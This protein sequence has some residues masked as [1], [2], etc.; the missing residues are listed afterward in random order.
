MD[1]SDPAAVSAYL[2]SDEV[3]V[4]AMPGGVSS[5]VVR[6]QTPEQSFVLKRALPKL[7]VKEDW[8]ANT[9]RNI[10]ERLCLQLISQMAP[11]FVPKVLF[12]DE[13]NGLFAMEYVEGLTWKHKLL[14]GHVDVQVATMLGRFLATVHRL[15]FANSEYLT[16]FSDKTL[17]HQLRISPYFEFILDLY[18]EYRTYLDEVIDSMMSTSDVLVH[19]DFSPKNVLL[20]TKQ[21]Q[22]VVLDWEVAH[23]GHASFD[24]SF[25][26]HHLLLKA[27]YAK[28]NF[29]SYLALV[30]TFYR[31]YFEVVGVLSESQFRAITW[32]TT[33]ALLLARVD[34]KSPVE[35]LN[36]QMKEQVRQIGISLLSRNAADMADVTVLYREVIGA[37]P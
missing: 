30:D 2:K 37:K 36:E 15:T 4:E 12:V 29:A 9:S 18:P 16:P 31:S 33:G 13:A 28:L 3:K 23:A 22:P 20:R 21:N 27:V 7:R 25:M 1:L 8:F 19:G 5:D 35:Y 32:Q 10:I 26:M 11:R 14:Q 24:I 17:F 6:V 34:G